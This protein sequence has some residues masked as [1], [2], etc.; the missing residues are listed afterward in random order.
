MAKDIT[1]THRG[2]EII[3]IETKEGWMCP[4]LDGGGYGGEIFDTLAEVKAKIND[5]VASMRKEASVPAFFVSTGHPPSLLSSLVTEY[6][7]LK[8]DVYGKPTFEGKVASMAIRGASKKPTRAEHAIGQFAPNT[9]EA[10]AA[11][12]EALKLYEAAK[13]ATKKYEAA[14]AAIPRLTKDDIAGLVKIYEDQQQ[15]AEPEKE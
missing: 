2:Y 14:I 15:P 9:P 6:L 1:T 11:F 12:G 3:Y 4:D 7:G 13:E 5:M 10:V 8:R